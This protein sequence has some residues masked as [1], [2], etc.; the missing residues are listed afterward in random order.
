MA[1]TVLCLLLSPAK[2]QQ[3]PPRQV[4]NGIY[5][6]LFLL[7]HDFSDGFVSLNYERLLGEKGRTYFR[8]GIYPDF[9][10]TVSFPM[11]ISRMT[12]PARRHHFEYG[13]GLV[14]RVEHYVD[15]Y[16]PAPMKTWFYDVPALMIPLMYRYQK[17]EGLYFRA[18]FN[19]FLSWP[20][21]PS[22]SFSMG[23]RF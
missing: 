20:V 17:N 10:S 18:G 16:D 23:Y 22:P 11:T 2:A 21:L 1:V 6:E 13:A 4:K 7:R 9:Q 5:A 3:D 19:V 12:G 8:L 14:F 15:P